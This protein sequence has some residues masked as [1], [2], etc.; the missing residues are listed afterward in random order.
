M[1]KGVVKGSRRGPYTPRG[2][3]EKNAPP[4][5]AWSVDDTKTYRELVESSP[6]AFDSAKHHL[7]RRF[8]E[9]DRL[10]RDLDSRPCTVE[11]LKLRVSASTA[12]RKC[13]EALKVVEKTNEEEEKL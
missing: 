7:A 2:G 13:L 4:V 9:L 6:L 12:S 8:V 3:G 11:E 10:C 1:P 5:G